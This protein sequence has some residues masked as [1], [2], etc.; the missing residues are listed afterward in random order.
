VTALLRSPTY[1]ARPAEGLDDVLARPAARWEPLVSDATWEAVQAQIAGHAVRP[2]QASGRYLLT[3]FLRCPRCGERMV[4]SAREREDQ[5]GSIRVEYRCTG[6]TRGANAPVVGCRWAVPM[7]HADRAVLDQV[8]DVL[9]ALADPDRLPALQR[10]WDALDQPSTPDPS[11]QMAELEREIQTAQ[12][13][14]ADAAGLLVD[15]SLDRL[16]YEVLRDRETA[17][18]QAAE[19]ERARV[20][21]TEQP[22]TAMQ[23]RPRLAHVLEKAGSW[24][25]IL[26]EVNVAAQRAILNE[27]VD[28]VVPMRDGYRAYLV[29]VTWTPLGQALRTA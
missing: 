26:R 24:G 8:A 7:K 18:I 28:R 10:A 4:G 1:V 14:L 25:R 6:W 19:T 20:R 16:G 23:K 17:R 22:R 11:R 2:H 15:G 5:V 13:R 9:A 21:P 12:R 3:G 27:L 29:K